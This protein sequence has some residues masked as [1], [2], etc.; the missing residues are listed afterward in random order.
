[1]KQK[2]IQRQLT[3]EKVRQSEELRR[4]V[5]RFLANGGSVQVIENGA[6]HRNRYPIDLEFESFHV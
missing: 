4:D 2:T 1:M 5:E 6:S 3:Q